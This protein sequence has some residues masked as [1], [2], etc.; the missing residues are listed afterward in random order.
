MVSDDLDIYDVS[1]A[2]VIR[3]IS[4]VNP[5]SL[6]VSLGRGNDQLTIGLV[7]LGLLTTISFDGGVDNDFLVAADLDNQ[8]AIAGENR[9]TLNGLLAFTNVESLIGGALSDR[10]AYADQA[11]V[12]GMVDGGSDGIDTLDYASF[13]TPLQIQLGEGNV[14]IDAV[15]GG[16]A[17][18][19]L[20]GL[21]ATNVWTLNGAGSGTVAATSSQ[22]LAVGR[23]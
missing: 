23:R 2:T 19:T 6:A 15:I 11:T 8:W 12:T 1:T 22:P 4:F 17:S 13:T 9:G 10:F 18:D 20:V 14:N 7:E 16:A 5:V 21:N 3:S